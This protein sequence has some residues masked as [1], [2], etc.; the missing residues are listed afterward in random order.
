MICA[1]L[2]N[3]DLFQRGKHQYTV[4]EFSHIDEIAMCERGFHASKRPTDI[5]HF[6]YMNSMTAWLVEVKGDIIEADDKLCCSDLKPIVPAS[7]E[8]LIDLQQQAG[9]NNRYS[10]ARFADDYSTVCAR[11][12]FVK[13][14]TNVRVHAQR[15]WVQLG[16]YARVDLKGHSLV[17]GGN[18]SVVNCNYNSNIGVGDNSYIVTNAR[19]DSSLIVCGELCN[20][21]IGLINRASKCIVKAGKN[22]VINAI[23]VAAQPQIYI[24]GVDFPENTFVFISHEGV[25]LITD[26]RK[27]KRITK[28]LLYNKLVLRGGDSNGNW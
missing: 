14:D 17:T 4:G 6:G 20:V 8:A 2:M 23:P 15:G 26:Q 16:D 25:D 22:T 10:V 19:T 12:V 5:L 28:A 18:N 9:G 7:L 24:S 3:H 11:E 13:G 21:D 27:A 1:K